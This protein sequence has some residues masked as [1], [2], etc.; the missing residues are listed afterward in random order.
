MTIAVRPEV[1]PAQRAR[2]RRARKRREALLGYAL[3][4]PA[5]L[6]FGVAAVSLVARP[7][8][9]PFVA[10]PVL[11]WPRPCHRH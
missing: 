7:S 10:M 6:V 2:R 5:L 8:A 1:S 4:A 9:P 11:S 3:V